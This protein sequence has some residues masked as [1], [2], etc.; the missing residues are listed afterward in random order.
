MPFIKDGRY[1]NLSTSNTIS[2][3]VISELNSPG[4]DGLIAYYPGNP[5]GL[6]VYNGAATPNK[7][8]DVGSSGAG[9]TSIAQGTGMSFSVNP[10]VATGTINLAIPVTVPHGGT[11][12]VTAPTNGQ[13]L[14]GNG[15]TYT[16]ANITPGAGISVTNGA[17]T[18]S[19]ASTVTGTVTSIAAGTGMTLTPDPIVATGTVALTVPVV[20]ANGGTGNTTFTSNGLLYGNSLNPIDPVLSTAAGAIGTVLTGTGGA[21]AFSATPTLGSVGTTGTLGFSGLTSGTVTIQPQAVAGTFNFNLPTTAGTTGQVLTSAGGAA[22]AMTWT[23]LNTPSLQSSSGA[24]GGA[25][26]PVIDT[27][28]VTT[29]ITGT[30]G[31]GNVSGTLAAGTDGMIKNIVC[32]SLAAGVTITVSGAFK[33]STGSAATAIRFDSVGNSAM[34]IWSATA[35]AW[36]NINAGVVLIP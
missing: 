32:I 9:V 12:L 31:A 14:I 13:L 11:G 28:S 36:L 16:L 21:P 35:A 33:S 30:G 8:V 29:F 2:I 24:S 15:A 27:T 19:I 34:L 17:G 26:S 7:W 1:N 20:V 22:A 18:I 5:N 23:N 4:S 10:I 3:P 25:L 6:Y